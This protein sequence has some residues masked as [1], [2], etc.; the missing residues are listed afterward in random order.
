[1]R[2][3]AKGHR[4]MVEA[5][6]RRPRV[7]YRLRIDY[8][9]PAREASDYGARVEWYEGQPP[10]LI[11]DDLPWRTRACSA[12]KADRPTGRRPHP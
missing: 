7:W 1:M 3:Y 5:Q 10:A 8:S 6:I 12:G 2:R 4:V 9:D 11:E